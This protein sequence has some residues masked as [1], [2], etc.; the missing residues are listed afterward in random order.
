MLKNYFKKTKYIAMPSEPK[1]I[2][3]TEKKDNSKVSIPEGAWLKCD[4]CKNT[5][6]K[7]DMDENQ[8]VCPHCQKHYRLDAYGRLQ[9]ILD[10]DTFKEFDKEL[11]S[12]NVLSFPNYSEKVNVLQQKTSL[13]SAVVT[14]EGLINGYPAVIAVM[15]S[16]FMM[17]SMGQAVGEKITRAIE[18]ATKKGLPI[19]IFTASGGARMQEGIFSL[20]QMAKTSAAL[21]KHHDAGLL[22][23]SVITDPTTGGVTASFAMLGDIIIAEPGALIGFAGRRVIE[24]TIGEK[25]PEDFQTAEFLMEHGFVDA[26]VPRKEMKETLAKIMLMHGVEQV[27]K[28]NEY[29]A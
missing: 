27:V 3:Q 16:R 18:K 12:E 2:P 5:L 13:R 17:G 23:I 9:L 10:D 29:Y 26:I 14:G 25:L 20:M 28:E 19:L 24:Q 15:D 8:K 22:Y 4:S 1:T 6:Y 21:A 11:E 7:K